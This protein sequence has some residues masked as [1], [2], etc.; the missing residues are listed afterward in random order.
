MTNVHCHKH[1]IITHTYTIYIHTK[2]DLCLA[3]CECCCIVFSGLENELV[4]CIFVARS[5]E[6]DMLLN[7]IFHL[8]ILLKI[9]LLVMVLLNVVFT[10]GLFHVTADF[11]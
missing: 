11:H 5:T 9:W 2:L 10:G 7:V 6:K 1:H 3:Y 4:E 8:A